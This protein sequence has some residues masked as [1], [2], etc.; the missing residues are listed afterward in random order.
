MALPAIPSAAVSN[1]KLAASMLALGFPFT[2]ELV[3]PSRS[4][5]KLHTQFL[6]K[7][8]SLRP[9]YA[10][11]QV[12]DALLWQS[13]R[14]DKEQPMHPLCIMMRAHDNYDRLLDWQKQGI[15]HGLKSVADG[16]MTLYRRATVR[17]FES[18]HFT[19]TDLDLVASLGG[20]GIP[21]T[22]ID[23]SDGSHLYR[24][25]RLG[26]ARRLTTGA[27]V[28][29]DALHLVALAP[30]SS[31]PR[32]LRLE[33]TDPAHPL[34]I[35][36]DALH[37]RALLK[38]A[39]STTTPLLLIQEEGSTLQSLITMNASGRVMRRVDQHFKSPPIR[40]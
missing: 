38:K 6:F 16:Q 18:G 1:T 3:Q 24:L 11:I 30:T 34:V 17:D 40:W 37:C 22:R 31:D 14:L 27:A 7:G 10:A 12:T 32:R 29:E 13:G 21:V 8:L 20:I 5:A 26:Y 35:M 28:Q 4:G 33:D 23:G 9:E 15:P 19:L 25:P 39:L 2:A 36:Y